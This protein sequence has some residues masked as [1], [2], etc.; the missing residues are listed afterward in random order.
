MDL[1]TKLNFSCFMEQ[2]QH[3]ILCW[4]RDFTTGVLKP[5]EFFVAASLGMQ[6]PNQADICASLQ[7]RAADDRLSKYTIMEGIAME[8]FRHVRHRF[9]VSM[10]DQY[11]SDREIDRVRVPH[12]APQKSAGL[13]GPLDYNGMALRSRRAG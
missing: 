5:G 4:V 8:F 1:L 6:S 3:F 11:R 13:G 9:S 2:L 10:M 7:S 12:T